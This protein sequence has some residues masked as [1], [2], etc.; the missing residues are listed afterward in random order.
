MIAFHPVQQVGGEALPNGSARVAIELAGDQTWVRRLSQT[1]HVVPRRPNDA[2]ELVPPSLQ[3]GPEIGML[4]V[5]LVH[6]G[7]V[8]RIPCDRFAV[9]RDIG[10][11][12]VNGMILPVEDQV[13]P[14][15]VVAASL[16]GFVKNTGVNV[17]GRNEAQII[18]HIM[19]RFHDGV[20]FARGH[21]VLG[22]RLVNCENRCPAT[23]RHVL[24]GCV[25]GKQSTEFWIQNRVLAQVPML[26]RIETTRLHPLRQ[27]IN[28]PRQLTHHSIRIGLR[29]HQ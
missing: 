4:G 11:L 5:V 6:G 16:A 12:P 29:V 28:R 21:E 25:P 23:G 14:A 10:V 22:A 27:H 24:P 19:Q 2:L 3:S 9:L 15:F 17:A 8:F 26:R 1:S 18:G 7:L 13:D 20:I